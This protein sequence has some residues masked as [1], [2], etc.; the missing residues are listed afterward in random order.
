[1]FQ[2]APDGACSR[3]R[4]WSET[5]WTEIEAE[6]TPGLWG[7]RT[8][9]AMTTMV[10]M[11]TEVTELSWAFRGRMQITD[12][13]TRT[14]QA[15]SEREGRVIERSYLAT[16]EKRPPN[17]SSTSEWKTRVRTQKPALTIALAR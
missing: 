9:S 12:A 3:E 13:A 5:A 4:V 14:T 10:L 2:C 16:L 15:F 1:M 11:A 17:S 8:F 7:S 6:R